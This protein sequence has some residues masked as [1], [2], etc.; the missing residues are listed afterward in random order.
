MLE[1]RT[2][3]GR[4]AI[5]Y[6][7]VARCKTETPHQVVF[8]RHATVSESLTKDCTSTVPRFKTITTRR[9]RASRLW[10]R[11]LWLSRDQNRKWVPTPLRLFLPFLNNHVTNPYLE[12]TLAILAVREYV[13]M[14]R[15]TRFFE[16][17][18]AR[19]RF[20]SRL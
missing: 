14:E 13:D 15:T 7:K 19:Q 16:E 11:S 4:G 3:S 1:E 6:F 20:K 18:R 17:E 12:S 5:S 8:G 2:R 9:E 10:F